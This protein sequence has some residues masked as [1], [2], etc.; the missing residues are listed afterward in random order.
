MTTYLSEKIQIK[1]I[2]SV[3][4]PPREAQR[5]QNKAIIFRS[6]FLSNNTIKNS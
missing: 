6:P 4:V 1:R 3:C 5:I 2:G